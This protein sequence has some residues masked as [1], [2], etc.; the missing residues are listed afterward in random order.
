MRLLLFW[1]FEETLI[2]K[3]RTRIYH[4]QSV[5]ILVVIDRYRFTL[6]GTSLVRRSHRDVGIHANSPGH[7]PCVGVE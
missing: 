3:L 7:Q 6:G 5:S 4:L 1:R 2:V